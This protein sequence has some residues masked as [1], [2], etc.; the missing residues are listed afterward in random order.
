M[1]E[2]SPLFDEVMG[3]IV[4]GDDLVTRDV[5][6]SGEHAPP[7]YETPGPSSP[8]DP[9]MRD[10]APRT[11]DAPRVL[12]LHQ[13]T[14]QGVADAMRGRYLCDRDG[15]GWTFSDQRGFD[16]YRRAWN[17]ARADLGLSGLPITRP[18][19]PFHLSYET[20]PD[21]PPPYAMHEAGL[22][23]DGPTDS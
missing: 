17:L 11:N 6:L 2:Q 3:V 12:P 5:R 8:R 10:G 22:D 7:A 21:D 15:F 23:H 18:E 4:S 19:E 14:E 20:A 1:P 13:A 9:W 16:Y